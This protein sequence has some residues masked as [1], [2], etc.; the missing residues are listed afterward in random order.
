MIEAVA[1]IE[2][3]EAKAG[4]V[5]TASQAPL[6]RVTTATT[7]ATN[8]NQPFLRGLADGTE[9]LE[10]KASNVALIAPVLKPSRH[11]NRRETAKGA[12]ER[13][14]G[15]PLLNFHKR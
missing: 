3:N 8:P 10:K 6:Q 1:A 4:Q 5:S 9:D 11:L 13:E 7:T 15:D 2:A 14:F 12:D